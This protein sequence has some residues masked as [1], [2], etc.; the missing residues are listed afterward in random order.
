MNCK[1]SFFNVF[2]LSYIVVEIQLYIMTEQNISQH[3]FHVV[4][5]MARIPENYTCV[6]LSEGGWIISNTL[7]HP[8]VAH[9]A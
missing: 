3:Y 9:C 1:I 8:R 2:V 5:N 4:L 7:A 6:T